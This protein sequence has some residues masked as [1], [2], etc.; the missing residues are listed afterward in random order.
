MSKIDT[1]NF[2]S[3]GDYSGILT[4]SQTINDNQSK[5]EGILSEISLGGEPLESSIYNIKNNS[6]GPDDASINEDT[7]MLGIF[8]VQYDIQETEKIVEEIDK[9]ITE[10]NKKIA[11]DNKKIDEDNKIIEE[12]T[13]KK[14]E[15]EKQKAKLNE[16]LTVLKE[17]YSSLPNDDSEKTAAEKSRLEAQIASLESQIASL[18]AEIDALQ[19]E[20]DRLTA[21]V[22]EL[23]AEVEAL[24]ADVEQ[25]TA[26]K[27][28]YENQIK[29][30]EEFHDKMVNISRGLGIARA[31]LIDTF[32]GSNGKT[33]TNTSTKGAKTKPISY[34]QKGYIGEDG[35]LHE[36]EYDNNG[37]GK[38]LSESGCGPTALASCLASIFNDPS[39]TPASIASRMKSYDENTGGNFMHICN[40]YGIEY[41]TNIGFSRKESDG[42]LTRD[43]VLDNGGKVIISTNMFGEGGTHYI[44]ILGKETING[45]TRYIVSDPYTDNPGQVLKLNEKELNSYTKGHTMTMMV[46]PKG[47]TMTQATKSTG[48]VQDIPV[49][50]SLEYNNPNTK[51]SGKTSGSTSGTVN[52]G[53]QQPSSG[54]P[55]NGNN[56]G[57][58]S[59]GENYSGTASSG[60]NYSGEMTNGRVDQYNYD[61]DDYGNSVTNTTKG[62]NSNNISNV[63]NRYRS[64]NSRS[65]DEPTN[66]YKTNHT[67]GNSHS[68]QTSYTNKNLTPTNES[69]TSTKNG[70]HLKTTSILNSLK[71]T[72]DSDNDS[73]S[74]NNNEITSQQNNIES[75]VT[76]NPVT[77]IISNIQGKSNNNTINNSSNPAGVIASIAGIGLSS[78]AAYGATKYTKNEKNKNNNKP[79][80]YTVEEYDKIK[81]NQEE[82]I[83]VN[84]DK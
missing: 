73:A 21:E 22:N 75:I 56:S 67:L 80:E 20:I 12:D 3:Y 2:S 51:S 71:D 78:G 27:E 28:D 76:D 49:L 60:G 83:Y 14:D 42:S 26:A 15:D 8:S 29:Q 81:K 54:E 39:I 16:Q 25:L 79:K 5:V 53:H 74:I 84:D 43:N 82:K 61:T 11:E 48:A 35:K 52:T 72:I 37:W 58:A 10:N 4:M 57:T 19:A 65:Y 46:A 30:K 70:N 69:I 6:T 38:K 24:T 13:K 68:T 18:Q 41:T 62:N 40:Q 9:K 77:K 17:Q 1:A 66:T 59:S 23:T 47:M 32:N 34:S 63:M 31:N 33:A 64:M 55:Y 44:A 45:E 50:T 7:L 36:W